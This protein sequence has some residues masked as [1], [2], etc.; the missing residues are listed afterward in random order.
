MIDTLIAGLVHG[1]AYALVALGL[2]LIFGVTNVANFAHGS[3]FAIG[4]M[5]GWFFAA[6]MG[7]PWWAALAGAIAVT[8]LVGWAVNLAAIRP[9]L[10]RPPIATL[11]ATVAVAMILDNLSQL[12]FGA[13]LRPFPQ[14]L[15]THNLKLAGI[16]FGTS[17]VVMFA[18]TIT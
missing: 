16:S 11:L 17:D 1:N 10:R 4:T 12:V 9:L 13:Q 6:E 7:W 18:V 14:V 3:V 2:S 8:A 15:P 5:A